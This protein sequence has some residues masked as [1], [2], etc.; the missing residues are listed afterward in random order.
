MERG[1]KKGS[2]NGKRIERERGREGL[3]V[4]ECKRG[5]GGKEE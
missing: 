2:E 4:G 3:R 5:E 1:G